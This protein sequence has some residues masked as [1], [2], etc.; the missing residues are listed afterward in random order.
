MK[1]LI[2]YLFSRYDGDA[3]DEEDSGFDDLTK[4][5]NQK[6]EKRQRHSF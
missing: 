6:T 1:N 5:G 3:D 2:R 4:S